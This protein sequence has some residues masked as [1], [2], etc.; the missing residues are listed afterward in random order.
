MA[1]FKKT[2]EKKDAKAVVK[3][4]NK[5]EKKTKA[6]KAVKADE[7]K[8]SS[9]ELVKGVI[10]AP[11][12]AEKS[13]L[14]SDKGIYTFVVNRNTTKAKIYK[15]IKDKYKVEPVK[16]NITNLPDKTVFVRGKFGIS[17]GVKKAIVF[18]KKGDKIEFI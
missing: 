12:V 7:A 10:I 18:L 11:R 17:R 16:I 2:E 14:L 1:L 8:D 9:K 15:A 5:T 3:A 4:E 13:A 6:T